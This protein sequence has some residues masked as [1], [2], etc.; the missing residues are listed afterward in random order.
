MTA[1]YPVFMTLQNGQVRRHSGSPITPADLALQN[2]RSCWTSCPPW[3]RSWGFYLPDD[4]VVINLNV[5]NYSSTTLKP[6]R[7]LFLCVRD[8]GTAAGLPQRRTGEL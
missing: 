2:G 3:R 6:Y 8:G 4:L 5:D 7:M 1:E